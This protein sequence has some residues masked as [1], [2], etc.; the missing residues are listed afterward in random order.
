MAAL[1]SDHRNLEETAKVAAISV[2]TLKTML[3]PEFKAASL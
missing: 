2:A 3:L 1:V